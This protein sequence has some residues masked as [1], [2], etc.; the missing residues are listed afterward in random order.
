VR[1][2]VCSQ[3]HLVLAW[4]THSAAHAGSPSSTLADASSTEEPAGSAV[5]GKSSIPDIHLRSLPSPNDP[6]AVSSKSVLNQTLRSAAPQTTY[7]DSSSVSVSGNRTPSWLSLGTP[8]ESPS[9]NRA[10][11]SLTTGK[12]HRSPHLSAAALQRNYLARSG[13]PL[14]LFFLFTNHKLNILIY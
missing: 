10:K 5:Q 12:V 4:S 13:I 8:P 9:E 3:E 2:K 6:T 7:A 14:N 1:K 11:A